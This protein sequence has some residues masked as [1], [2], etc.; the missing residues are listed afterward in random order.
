MAK[1]D[2]GLFKPL[3]SKRAFEEI[4]DQIKRL[5]YSGNSAGR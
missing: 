4:A 3:P 1:V 2:R 5:I